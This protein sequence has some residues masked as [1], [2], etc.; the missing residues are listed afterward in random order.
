MAHKTINVYDGNRRVTS[1]TLPNTGATMTFAYTLVNSLIPT[2]PVTQTVV[3]DP[4]GNATTYRFNTNEFLV[5]V[6]DASGQDA[7]HNPRAGQQSYHGKGFTG[8][9]TCSA[10]ACGDTKAG[11]VTFTYDANGNML[12]QTAALGETTMYT[13]DP[14]LQ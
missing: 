8:P 9:G 7:N 3:T 1:Q 6:T 10:P 2:S 4:M 5:G 13:Y 11:D 14:G 12:S